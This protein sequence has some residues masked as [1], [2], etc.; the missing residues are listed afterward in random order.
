MN[1]ITIRV[2]DIDGEPMLD[3]TAMS[4]LFGVRT[5]EVSALPIGNGTTRLPTEWLK[6]GR[7]RAREA[8]AHT[9]SDAMLDNLRYWARQDHAAELEVVYQ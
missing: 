3:A 6:R 5:E 1:T 7:R 4:L 9:G 2:T 8:M